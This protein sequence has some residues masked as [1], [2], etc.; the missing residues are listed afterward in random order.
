M[1]QYLRE[2]FQ[3]NAGFIYIDDCNISKVFTV[4][5]QTNLL[6]N[7]P[8]TSK[9]VGMDKIDA[10]KLS[11]EYLKRL[12][13]NRVHFSEFWL[14][15]SYAKNASRKDSDIDL[16]IVLDD[17]EEKSFETEVKL[18]IIREGEETAIEPHLFTK[19]E[20][21]A[22]TPIVRQIVTTGEKIA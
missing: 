6:P 13:E 17:D 7:G 5:V 22:A 20:F 2:R 19:E 16:A 12:S 4:C 1:G 10:I 15:G 3:D 8:K 11:E 18:M 21:A 14:F 9:I